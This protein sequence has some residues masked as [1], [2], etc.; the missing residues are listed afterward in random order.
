MTS[1]ETSEELAKLKYKGS[2][3][4]P[5]IVTLWVILLGYCLYYL[6]RFFWPALRGPAGS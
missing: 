2:R 4:P 1:H 5:F 3:V 6:V